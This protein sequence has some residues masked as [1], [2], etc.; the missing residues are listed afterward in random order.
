MISL[1]H[2]HARIFEARIEIGTP[3]AS[4]WK[5]GKFESSVLHGG[6]R[7][8][9]NL[10]KGGGW[11]ASMKTPRILPSISQQEKGEFRARFP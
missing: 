2:T 5:S 3:E 8:G 11:S 6:R 4:T 10:H 9:I 7:N 1:K